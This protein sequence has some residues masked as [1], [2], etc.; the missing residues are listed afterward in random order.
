MNID[1]LKQ[2]QED[3]IAQDKKQKPASKNYN[4]Y[5]YSNTVWFRNTDEY[6]D[7]LKEYYR[8]NTTTYEE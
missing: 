1:K 8:L 2:I 4:S 3:L 5:T 7:Y 6:R